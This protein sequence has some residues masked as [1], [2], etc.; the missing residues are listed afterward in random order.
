MLDFA[1]VRPEA[2][3]LPVE[4]LEGD[5]ARL[6]FVD[7]SLDAVWM[8]RVLIHVENPA[9][10]MAEI[11]RVLRPGGR[12]VLYESNHY[13]TTFDSPDREVSDLIAAANRASQRN[14]NVGPALLRLAHQAGF[15]EYELEPEL[16]RVRDFELCAAGFR[17]REVL[18]RLVDDKTISEARA[19]EWWQGMR[20]AD[21]V[22]ILF[23]VTPVFTLFATR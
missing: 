15:A 14:P 17:W 13:G 16:L 7:E 4:F 12:A 2:Q 6:P 1:R 5:V 22:G 10:V 11:H 23:C 3:D 8:E 18:S 21:A 20:D 19:E 9:G